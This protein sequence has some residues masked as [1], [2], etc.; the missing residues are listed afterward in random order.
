MGSALTV[1]DAFRGVKRVFPDTAPVIYAVEQDPTFSARTL[2][3]LQFCSAN[4]IDL[5]I[6]PVTVAEC[7]SGNL[8]ALQL[9]TK[10]DSLLSTKEI[11]FRPYNETAAIYAGRLRRETT[12]KLPDAMQ[13]SQALSESCDALFTNDP[14]IRTKQSA[15]RTILVLELDT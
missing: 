9:K 3:A 13:V 7:T 11:T 5:V 12:L 1:S 6:G 15:I 8:S 2:R 14:G 4:N 10:T